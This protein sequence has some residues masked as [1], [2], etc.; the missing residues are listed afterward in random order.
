MKD[1]KISVCITTQ[2]IDLF[3]RRAIDSVLKQT[4][5][6]FEVLIIIDGL[7]TKLQSSISKLN[8]PH[9]WEIY[10]T[11]SEKSGPAIPKNVGM[12]YAKGDWIL[13]LDG[14]DFL[15]P[16]C[17]DHYTK[18]IP[19]VKVDVIAELISPA[20]IHSSLVV[21]KNLPPD[22]DS[23]DSYYK[24]SIKTL[25]SGSWK[26]GDLPFRPLLIKSEGKKFFPHDYAYYEDKMLCLHYILE[27]RRI[28]IS[29]YCGYI[30]NN[31]PGSLTNT[32]LKWGQNT[33]PDY[34]RFKRASG[35]VNINGW[36]VKDKIFDL[37]RSFSFLTDSD[38]EYI[39]ETVKYFSFL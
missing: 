6:P 1:Q 11:E 2:K 19:S 13:L 17:I 25:F 32:L 16:S 29:D 34:V 7:S 39:D 18:I 9:D 35:N 20:L 37:Y 30:V 8:L 12:H 28:H 14:D 10:W 24:Y 23:W 38:F 36:I 26:R 33:H 5:K 22:K 31:H 27:E 3:F 21:T 15:A 4:Y